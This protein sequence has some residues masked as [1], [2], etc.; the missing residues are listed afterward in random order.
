MPLYAGVWK[1]I[2]FWLVLCSVG[3]LQANVLSWRNGGNGEY[4]DSNPPTDWKTGELWNIGL[5]NW[6]NA[7]PILVDGRLYFCQEP[8]TLICADSQTGE[9]LWQ[10]SNEL[11]DVLGFSEEEK[12]EGLR[13]QEQARMKRQERSQL[14]GERYRLTRRLRNDPENEDLKRLIEEKESEIQSINDWLDETSKDPKFGAAATVHTHQT[15]GYTSF[16]PLSDGKR[17]YAAFGQ[18][19]LAAYDL[20]GNKVWQKQMEQPNPAL[21]EYDWGGSTSPQIVDGKLIVRFSD[22]TALNPET[23]EELWRTPSMPV[24][25]TPA[26]FEVE[27]QFFLFT[28]R[29]ELIQ[30]SDGKIFQK[31]LVALHPNHP[32]AVFNSP[33][34]ENGIIY[35]VRGRNGDVTDGHAYAF[36]IPKDLDTLLDSG[37][38]EIWHTS[39]HTNRYYASPIAHQGLLYALSQDFVFTVLEMDT[40]EKVLEHKITGLKGVAYPSISL[41]GDKLFLASDTGTLVVLQPGREYKELGRSQFGEFRSTP[42]FDGEIA[43]LRTYSEIMAIKRM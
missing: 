8:S 30:A 4:A 28:P 25:G 2:V 14:R 10:R 31:G 7:S 15:N 37:L 27:G 12:A 22:Y 35:T 32:W 19:V 34:I 6:S 23:G 39:I 16:T 13:L 38:E 43:Y 42:I 11:I 3:V 41:A 20:E 26:V 9:V 36:R 18:G 21:G 29:G 5:A 40:G 24:Y 1:K 33:V 17:V